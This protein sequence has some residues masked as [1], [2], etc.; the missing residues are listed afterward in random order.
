MEQICSG[1]K[2]IAGTSP[3]FETVEVFVGNCPKH[4]RPIVVARCHGEGEILAGIGDGGDGTCDGGEGGIDF[5]LSEVK[6]ARKGVSFPCLLLGI[7]I[8]RNRKCEAILVGGEE[9]GMQATAKGHGSAR[10][11]GIG[12]IDR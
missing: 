5:G 3:R 10:F 12:L 11:I 7:A 4:D 6:F 8:G 2:V 1:V 9:I